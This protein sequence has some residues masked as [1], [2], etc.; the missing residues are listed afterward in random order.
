M[1]T[2]TIRVVPITS[3]APP[4]RETLDAED[5]AALSA[6]ADALIA[7][8][9]AGADPDA[10]ANESEAGT[11]I[12]E[13]APARR[14]AER[15]ARIAALSPQQQ[16][17]RQAMIARHLPLARYVAN[18]M[19]RHTGQSVLLDYDDLLSYGIEGLIA[20]VDTFDADR[21]LKFSTWAVMH[22]RT[23]IQDALRTLDPLPRSLRAKGKEIDRVAADL[24]HASGRWPELPELAEALGRP[25]DTLR[26]TMQALGHTVVS[27][28][29]VDDGH[30]G[31]ATG[32]DEAG[33]SLLNLLAD[34]DPDVSPSERLEQRELSRLLI[35][36]IRSLPPREEVLIDAHYCRGKSMREVS[37]MLFISESRVSQLHARAIKLLREFM[38]RALA[39]DPAPA[40]AA[41]RGRRAAAQLA[42]R[43]PEMLPVAATLDSRAA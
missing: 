14:R 19:S 29:Q 2:A 7:A 36:A 10:D 21:G 13:N 35:D 15:Y 9:D 17:E 39:V 25:L 31:A 27:L 1:D 42:A 12:A 33:F 26:R 32:G 3:P 20:A 16:A 6:A 24:A 38:Q 40:A 34:E 41:K 37:R 5:A 23:T 22:I 8:A 43:R 4:T 28:E 30:N 11:T 18:A